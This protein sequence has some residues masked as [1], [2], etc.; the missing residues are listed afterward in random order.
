MSENPWLSTAALRREEKTKLNPD[1]LMRR[2]K[3]IHQPLWQ[4]QIQWWLS[5]NLRSLCLLVVGVD[6]TVGEVRIQ[7]NDLFNGISSHSEELFLLSPFLRLC[8][9]SLT[10]FPLFHPSLPH[11]I[12]SP[13]WRRHKAMMLFAAT[14]IFTFLAS[15]DI[16]FEACLDCLHFI[17]PCFTFITM[18]LWPLECFPNK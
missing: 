5:L 11:S 7:I 3:E 2:V 18:G 10:I 1:M 17:L 12:F 15:C 8:S 13:K 6:S 9:G 14:T 16:S 4:Q